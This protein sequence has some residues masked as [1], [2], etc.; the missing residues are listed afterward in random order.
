SEILN[1]IKRNDGSILDFIVQDILR[2]KDFKELLDREIETEK[3]PEENPNI[4]ENGM[5]ININL[6]KDDEDPGDTFRLYLSGTGTIWIDWGDGT[7]L[8]EVNLSN[9]NKTYYE[10]KYDTMNTDKYTVTVYG[11]EN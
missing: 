1:S 3:E 6:S 9:S 11:Q 8:E 4:Q 5:V 10:H 7:P 2:D